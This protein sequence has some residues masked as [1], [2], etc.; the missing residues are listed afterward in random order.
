MRVTCSNALMKYRIVKLRLAPRLAKHLQ[1]WH[2]QSDGTALVHDEE[3]SEYSN[4]DA[5]VQGQGAVR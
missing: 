3:G 4:L 1:P 2:I 5:A